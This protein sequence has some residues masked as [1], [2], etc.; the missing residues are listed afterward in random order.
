MKPRANSIGVEKVIE[1]FHIVPSQL[2]ILMPVG[3]AIAMVVIVNTELAIGPRP[4]VNMWWLQTIQPMKPMIR[5]ESTTTGYP[6]SGFFE[7]VGSISETMPIAGRMRMY[8]S[9]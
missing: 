1:P 8:T 6:N 2:N 4:T 7:K 9:G 5:P 3:T